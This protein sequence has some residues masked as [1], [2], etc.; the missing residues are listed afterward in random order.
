MEGSICTPL[1]LYPQAGIH[2]MENERYRRN[3]ILTLPNHTEK[4]KILCAVLVLARTELH[5]LP[6]AAVVLVASKK[7]KDFL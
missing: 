4:N 1:L 7:S 3:Q 6:V 5:F 2:K